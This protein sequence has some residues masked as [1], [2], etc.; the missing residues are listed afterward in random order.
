[1]R[2]TGLLGLFLAVSLTTLL[3][4]SADETPIPAG[5]PDVDRTREVGPED[6]PPGVPDL[7][8]RETLT[9]NW[10]G[11]GKD[12]EKI[13]IEAAFSVTQIYQLNLEGGLATHRHAGRYTGSYDL[14]VVF[15]LETL[16]NWAGASVY[17]HAEGSWSEG[18]SPGSIGDM[19]GVNGDAAGCRPI[20][21][22]ELWFEQSLFQDKLVI[23][24]GKLTLTGGF[25]CAGCPVSFDG[26][27]FA[28]DET[29]QFLNSA[30]VN[31]PTIPFPD[32]GLAVVVHAE[33]IPGWYISGG[34][35]DA[36]ADIRETGFRTTFHGTANFFAIF[37]TGLVNSTNS[38]RLGQLWGAYR[39]GLWYDPQAKER[40]SDGRTKTDD[41]GF[42]LSIDQDLFRE[43]P[44]QVDDPQ[45]LSAFARYGWADGAVNEIRHFWSFGLQYQGLVPTRD[46]DVVA[47]GY[48]HG[49]L[50]KAAGYDKSDEAV[51]EVYYNMQ[52]AGW[53]A[54][55]PSVQYVFHPGGAAG[56][57]NALVLGLRAQMSF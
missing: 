30:L 23:R 55:T 56:V 9:H 19:F 57:D 43:N 51:I 37:E 21:L 47:I 35:A 34:V 1:M 18:L 2:T 11:L 31:N 12:L 25:E 40:F 54:I 39:V 49:R 13:G 42:Y 14:E 24:A 17:A 46:D 44:R 4:A 27:R 29:G 33:P 20:D 52:V 15:N 38:E 10:F 22:T 36:D 50:V 6:E 28:N 8:E 26:N 32:N 3:P 7:M 45:G 53:L 5:P 41:L 16:L 48:A